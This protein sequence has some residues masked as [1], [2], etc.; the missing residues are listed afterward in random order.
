MRLDQVAP[1]ALVSRVLVVIGWAG[2]F[3]FFFMRKSPARGGVTK[4]EPAS[5]LG[6]VLQMVGFSLV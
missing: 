5:R 4:R 6:I 2:F 1:L 3:T